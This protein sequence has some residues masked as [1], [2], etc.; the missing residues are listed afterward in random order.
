[1]TLLRSRVLANLYKDERCQQLPS[2]GFLEKVYLERI[3][4]RPE[5]LLLFSTMNSG[6]KE[7]FFK[8][9][10]ISSNQRTQKI[11]ILNFY[12]ICVI[13]RMRKGR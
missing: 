12:E 6:S 1:M 4:R 5:A 11:K 10:Q 7:I 13:K 3:L 9:W 2:F 8:D